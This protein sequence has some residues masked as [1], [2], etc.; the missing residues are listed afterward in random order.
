MCA[1]LDCIV[2]CCAVLFCVALRVLKYSVA[3]GIS[4][5]TQVLTTPVAILTL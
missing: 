1:V 4:Y 3:V 5:G 2:L